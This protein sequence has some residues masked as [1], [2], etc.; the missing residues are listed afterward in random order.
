MNIRF[1]VILIISFI[2]PD[3]IIL[4]PW[5]AGAYHLPGSFPNK[6]AL[7]VTRF[8]DMEN[9]PMLLLQIVYVALYSAHENVAFT[10]VNMLL[11]F[12]MMTY[13]VMGKLILSLCNPPN[14][15]DYKDEPGAEIELSVVNPVHK[16]DAS[17]G[18]HASLDSTSGGT[19][20]QTESGESSNGNESVNPLH[21][22]D[23][24][25]DLP[26]GGTYEE[27]MKAPFPCAH[28]SCTNFHDDAM[29]GLCPE[30]RGGRSGG[31]GGRGDDGGRGG[32]CGMCKLSPAAK[33]RMAKRNNMIGV[34]FITLTIVGY[35]RRTVPISRKPLPAAH[36]LLHSL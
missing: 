23:A 19:I 26:G 10:H 28:S 9:I 5:N 14:K 20:K 6:D 4:L 24:D 2:D 1:I 27:F 3:A 8:K 15:T 25:G 31:G 21:N 36:S 32:L 11:T 12:C 33:A 34:G 22:A 18:Q 29:S 13:G 7:A 16:A 35:V 30:H 17:G